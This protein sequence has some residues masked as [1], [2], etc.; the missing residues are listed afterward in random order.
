MRQ[1]TERDLAFLRLS[2]GDERLTLTRRK[3]LRAL[4][5]LGRDGKP[6]T[7][8]QALL[9][10][11]A[12]GHRLPRREVFNLGGFPRSRPLPNAVTPDDAWTVKRVYVGEAVSGTWYASMA[13]RA[14]RLGLL[15]RDGE[16]LRLTEKGVQVLLLDD[17]RAR[18]AEKEA[19][20]RHLVGC[21]ANGTPLERPWSD[22]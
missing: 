16:D 19:D 8:G 4:G 3:R 9:E 22:A 2:S 6:T 12:R 1:V 7:K 14:I 13:E 21:D 17:S 10:L 18:R 20:L 5:L 15:R 11:Q